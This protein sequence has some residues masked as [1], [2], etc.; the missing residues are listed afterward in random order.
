MNFDPRDA[1]TIMLDDKLPEYPSFDPAYR[2]APRREAHLTQ[3]DKELAI[4]NALRYIPQQHHAQMAVEFAQELEQTG[5]IYGYR[6]RPEGKLIGK[7]IDEYKGNCVEAKAFQVMIDNNLDFDVALYPYE[8][9]T[10][11]ETGQVCQNWMQY[12]LIKKYLEVMTDEQTLVVMSGHPLGLFHSHKLAPRCIITNGLMVGA[13]DDQ[14]NFNRAAALGV[15]NYGQMTAGGWMYIGPQGIVHG[16]F[17]TL[18]NAGR[19]KLGIPADGNLAGKLFVTA[20]LGGMSGAQGKAAE[21]AGAVSIIAEVDESRIMTRY[22]QGWVSAKTDSLEEALRLAREKMAAKEPCA[23]AYLGNIVDLLKYLYENNVHVDL[24]SDQT[25]C[26]VP[27]DGGYCPQGLTFAQRTEMLAND[28]E[29]FKVLVDKTLRHHY[30]MIC[31][32]SDRGTYFFDY[33]NSF[34]KAV[35]DAGVKS[36][37]KNGENDLDGFIFP[38]YVEDILGPCLFDFGYGPFRW[39]CLS[40]DPADLDK[41]DAAAAEYIL[42][43]NRR[44]QDYD[45]YVWVRDAKENKL[46]V[47]TQCRILYQDA[48]GRM[49]IA[50]Y[51][52]IK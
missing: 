47:G 29:G 34:L 4:R 37:C 25:S 46:V 21:I 30:E 22:T 2:R 3:A 48:M 32:F 35:Y 26:H 33:G 41:T 42:A 8:L 51:C 27:Y 9:V 23:I 10:Y 17:N 5:R 7:P 15:A 43:N 11:G 16:T 19:L 31:K 13:F 52:R 14:K 24:M 39:C 20:G 18:L 45:N 12:R 44:Y 40:R 28:P 6:F 1:M 38:S 36:I 49:K 50:L